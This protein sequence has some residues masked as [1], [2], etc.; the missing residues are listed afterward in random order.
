MIKEV[1]DIIEYFPDSTEKKRFDRE[2]LFSVF[3]MIRYEQLKSMAKNS[4]KQRVKENDL[5]EDEFIY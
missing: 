1:F 4:H 5:S 3:A 2:Y